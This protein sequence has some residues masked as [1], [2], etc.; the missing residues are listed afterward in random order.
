MPEKN[1]WGSKNVSDEM[2]I[3]EKINRGKLDIKKLFY[4]VCCS[5]ATAFSLLKCS[6]QII[7]LEAATEICSFKVAALHLSS[8]PCQIFGKGF[9]F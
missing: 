8:K 2:R 3:C 6:G 1:G 7:V 5:S 9:N 4:T